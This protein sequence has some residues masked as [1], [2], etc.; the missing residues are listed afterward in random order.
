MTHP[1]FLTN[2][3]TIVGG[4]IF[5]SPLGAYLAKVWTGTPTPF[6][7]VFGPIEDGLTRF[8]RLGRA[9][10]QDGAGYGACLLAFNA[11]GFVLVY[12]LWRLSTVGL[13]GCARSSPVAPDLAFRLAMG[14]LEAAS[15]DASL[16]CRGGVS[17]LAVMGLCKIM[18][19]RCNGT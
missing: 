1:V 17:C 4:A 18:M 14:G 7:R 19:K 8:L 9:Q 5:G 6:S 12:G 16:A 11:V 15:A 13:M 3:L 10:A 2:L